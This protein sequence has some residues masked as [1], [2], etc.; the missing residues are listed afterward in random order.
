MK[1]LLSMVLA[2]AMLLGFG[3]SARADEF[4][5]YMELDGVI[6]VMLEGN[7]TTGFE[8]TA[9]SSDPEITDLMTLDYVASEADAETAGAGGVYIGSIETSG[10]KTGSCVVTFTYARS[11]EEEADKVYTLDLETCEAGL[12]VV[13]SGMVGN[14]DF[15]TDMDEDWVPFLRQDEETGIWIVSLPIADDGAF[16]WIYA[17]SVPGI[18]EMTSFEK[19]G[20]LEIVCVPA[21]GAEGSADLLF[22]LTDLSSMEIT[23]VKLLHV[24]VSDGVLNPEVSIETVTI[25]AWSDFD[26]EEA[27]DDDFT[28]FG[29]DG[30]SD[31]EVLDDLNLWDILAGALGEFMNSLTEEK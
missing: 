10:K 23:D 25:S 17:A 7:P 9:E 29:D 8:W 14:V 2:L 20:V 6:L 21:E 30:F 19:D 26:D 18:V 13:G 24:S 16:Q 1:K 22:D 27:Y 12:T 5:W 28:E 4:D 15:E 11:W 31:G 3:A